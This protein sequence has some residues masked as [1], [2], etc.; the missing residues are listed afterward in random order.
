MKETVKTLSGIEESFTKSTN[1]ELNGESWPN[2]SNLFGV[3]ADSTTKIGDWCLYKSIRETED[4]Y[5]VIEEIKVLSSWPASKGSNPNS[6][7]I[8]YGR[9]KKKTIEE[10]RAM[11]IDSILE[12]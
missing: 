6:S 1:I 12:K 9:G 10:Y 4:Y 3:L 11:K 5:V 7:E 8:Y 2:Y